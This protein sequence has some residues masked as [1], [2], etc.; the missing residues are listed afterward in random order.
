MADIFQEVDEELRRHRAV[1]LWRR[2][3]IYVI[4]AAVVLVLATAA[5]TGWNH[6]RTQQRIEAGNR[7]T[8]GLLLA[9]QGQLDEA[10]KLFSEVEGAPAAGFALLARFETAALKQRAGDRPGAIAIYD[11]IAADGKAPDSYREAA[12][13]LSVMQSADDGDPKALADRLAPIAAD[14]NPW[15]FM[16]RELQAVLAHRAGDTARARTMLKAL[17]DDA[18]APAA[19]RARAA[20]MSQALDGGA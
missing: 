1:Q 15:R 4:G 7:F 12:L 13:L 10:G 17:S 19:L 5:W 6:Y 8:A 16:A 9:N 18:A 3:G 20:E 14:A 11:A 2:Y